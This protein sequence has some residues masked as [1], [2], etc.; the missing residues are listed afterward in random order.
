M[1]I[2]CGGGEASR[3]SSATDDRPGTRLPVVWVQLERRRQHPGVVKLHD[4]RLNIPC[5]RHRCQGIGD[6][7]R[8]ATSCFTTPSLPRHV[9]ICVTPVSW[10]SRRRRCSTTTS[11][12]AA[13]RS[14]SSPPPGSIQSGGGVRVEL[15]SR[16]REVAPEHGLGDPVPAVHEATVGRQDDRVREIG[17]LDPTCVV[18]NGSARCR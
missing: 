13:A 9:S 16:D 1:S 6:R 2:A 15:T 3:S 5:R 14:A 10:M 7:A 17:C 18:R 8:S 4:S 11:V 12:A